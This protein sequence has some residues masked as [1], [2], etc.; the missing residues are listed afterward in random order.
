MLSNTFTHQTE[1]TRQQ[2]SENIEEKKILMIKVDNAKVGL[3]K[4][5]L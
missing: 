1:D 5:L 4:E 3:I 2:I